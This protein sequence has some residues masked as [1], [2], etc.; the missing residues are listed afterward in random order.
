MQTPLWQLSVWVQALLSL[1]AVPSAMGVPTQPVPF[2]VDA[3]SQLVGE[4]V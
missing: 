3:T 2:G 4:Q 1:H